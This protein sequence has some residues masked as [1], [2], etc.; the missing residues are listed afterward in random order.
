[1]KIFFKLL[2]KIVSFFSGYYRSLKKK[3]YTYSVTNTAKA[4][5]EGLKVNGKSIVNINTTLGN[6]VNFNGMAIL[7]DG[8]VVIGDN[9]H[10][11]PDCIIMTSYHNYDKGSAIPYDSTYIHKNV[12]IED[13]VWLG[14]K[15]IILGGVTI[16]EGAIIQIGSVVVSDIPPFAIAG[17]HPAC[18]YKYR[19]KDHYFKL[20]KEG[21]FH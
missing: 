7:G 13:N 1:M 12:T 11:G 2:R 18:V 20:K 21:K 17:G 16:G 8:I 15:V 6:N 14:S 19:D 10:S 5:G 3:Y 4:V 9:F